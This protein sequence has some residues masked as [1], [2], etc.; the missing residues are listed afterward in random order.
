MLSAGVAVVP[1][2]APVPA[3]GWPCRY[4]WNSETEFVVEARPTRILALERFRRGRLPPVGPPS[5]VDRTP[6]V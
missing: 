1:S 6:T 3:A 4:S 5:K 2:E